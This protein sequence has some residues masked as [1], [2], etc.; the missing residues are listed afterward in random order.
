M[1]KL[2]VHVQVA[3]HSNMPCLTPPPLLPAAFHLPLP[4]GW[5]DER[6]ACPSNAFYRGLQ[7]RLTWRKIETTAHQQHSSA[8]APPTLASKLHT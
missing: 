3:T 1:A 4:N 7:Q 8:Q 5:A 6:V 2:H